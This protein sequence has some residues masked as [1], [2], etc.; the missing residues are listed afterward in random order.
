MSSFPFPIKLTV[1]GLPPNATASFDISTF[2]LNGSPQ[3]VTLTVQTASLAAVL[4]GMDG[5]LAL[6]MLILPL[7]A[8]LRRRMGRSGSLCAVARFGCV[9]FLGALAGCGSGTGFFGQPQSTY[10]ITVTA[11]ATAP[12]GTHLQHSTVVTLTVQ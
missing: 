3:A 12:D 8:S 5:S 9:L 4:Y 6:A 1:D 2:T 10:N 11:T 7:A